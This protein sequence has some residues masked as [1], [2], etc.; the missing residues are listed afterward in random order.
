MFFFFLF[1]LQGSILAESVLASAVSDVN[2]VLE[3]V[4][5]DVHVKKKLFQGTGVRTY[6]VWQT[7][8]KYLSSILI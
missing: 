7:Q 6:Y 4:K 3:A 5:E 8:V 2:F 1:L